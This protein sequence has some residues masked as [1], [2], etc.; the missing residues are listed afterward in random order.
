MADH[1]DV[2]RSYYNQVENGKS[3]LKSK[4]LDRVRVMLKSELTGERS[5]SN[6]SEPQAAYGGL[7]NPNV[8]N[9]GGNVL[10]GSEHGSRRPIGGVDAPKVIFD[11][12]DPMFEI[13][14]QFPHD[15]HTSFDYPAMIR[16]AVSAWLNEALAAGAS[17]EVVYHKLSE[18]LSSKDW[19]YLRY[20]PPPQHQKPTSPGDAHIK[21][22]PKGTPPVFKS[23]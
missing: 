2:N 6:A 14:D 4:L 3:E 19:A 11:T 20:M 7:R 8:G 10:E 22:R 17:P 1:L 23:Q 15:P 21:H 9:Q 18:K 13:L 12:N 5:L 16:M